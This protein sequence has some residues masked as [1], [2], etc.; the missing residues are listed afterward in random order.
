[1]SG[2]FFDSNILLYLL[3]GS[4]PRKRDVARRLVY[5]ALISGDSAVSFQ[6]VQESLNVITTKV[7]TPLTSDGTEEFVHKI[8]FPLWKVHPSRG[9]YLKGMAIKSRYEY[10]FYDSLIIAAALELG[11]RTLYS[12]D[13]H[14]GH[15]IEGLTIENPFR[16]EQ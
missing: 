2:N 12:E 4:A 16:P 10:S 1:M 8:L 7:P 14:H 11:C 5:Q 3:D 6:V 15:Q 13:M 9:L